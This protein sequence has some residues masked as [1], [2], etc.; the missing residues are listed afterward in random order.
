M[1]KRALQESSSSESLTNDAKLRYFD[2]A[3]QTVLTCSLPPHRPATFSSQA[4]FDQHYLN[5]HVNRCSECGSNLPSP[6]FLF[7]HISENHDPLRDARKTR[8]EKTVGGGAYI[9]ISGVLTEYCTVHVFGR[10]L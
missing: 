2:G 6:H 4:E 3:E 5:S 10:R 9:L 8:G 7:V 1:S